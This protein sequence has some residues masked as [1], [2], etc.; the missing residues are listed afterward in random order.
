[1]HLTWWREAGR[2]SK[3]LDKKT[4]LATEQSSAIRSL[5]GQRHAEPATLSLYTG[6][7]RSVAKN[8][9]VSVLIELK[10]GHLKLTPLG[11][12]TSTLVARSDHAFYMKEWDGEAEFHQDADGNWLLD[13]F[14]LPNET[15]LTLRKS[16]ANE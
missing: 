1:M 13:I 5:A 12:G 10:D 11:K 4:N 7:Y 2:G 15:M 9:D 8:D 3:E 6:T 14:T 16:P